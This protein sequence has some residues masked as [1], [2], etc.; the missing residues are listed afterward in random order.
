MLSLVF[1]YF[2][3]LFGIT[4][5]INLFLFVFF[6]GA[7]GLAFRALANRLFANGAKRRVLIL[8]INTESA[9]LAQTISENPQLGYRVRAFVRTHQEPLTLDLVSLPTGMDI[10]AE[11]SNLAQ[12]VR[13]KKIDVI[14]VSPEAYESPQLIPLFENVINQGVEFMRLADFT[15][16]ITGTVPLGAISYRWFVDTMGSPKS[17]ASVAAK[18]AI[19]IVG[20]LILSIPTLAITPLVALG[21]FISSPGPLFYSHLRTGRNGKPFRIYKFRSMKPDAEAQ[22]GVVW[23]QEQDPCKE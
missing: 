23:A 18:R 13:E 19:D 21:I 2:V 9:Q 3:P 4:P 12:F 7:I 11:S 17:T 8:G 20:A 14:V 22:T 15:E 16:E 6:F 5:K 1:F 10:V